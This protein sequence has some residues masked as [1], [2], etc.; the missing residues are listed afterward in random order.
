M[1]LLSRTFYVPASTADAFDQYKSL[2]CR[3]DS[4]TAS[5]EEFS[6]LEETPDEELHWL[7]RWGVA[8]IDGRANF[9]PAQGG[10]V[11]HVSIRSIGALSR[12]V[13]S[14]AAPLARGPGR[15]LHAFRQ[16]ARRYG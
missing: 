6:L 5:K 15:H 10:C 1:S 16:L 3:T 4:G 12:L 8:L 13:L 9:I 14:I 11:V 2:L 7:S